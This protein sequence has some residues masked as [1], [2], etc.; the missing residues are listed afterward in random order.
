[1]RA[2]MPNGGLRQSLIIDVKKTFIHFKI[3]VTLFTFLLKLDSYCLRKKCN[4]Q[5]VDKNALNTALNSEN[6]NC[7]RLRGH[8]SNRCVLNS[9]RTK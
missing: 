5:N 9:A 3:L 1:M 8:V 2:Y 4:P 6:M 7:V